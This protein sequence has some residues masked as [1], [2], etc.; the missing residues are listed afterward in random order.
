MTKDNGKRMWLPTGLHD[1]IKR[2]ADTE[3]RSM[4][5]ELKLLVALRQA[6]MEHKPVKV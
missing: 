4:V 5:D 2:L 3:C 6:Q 1:E